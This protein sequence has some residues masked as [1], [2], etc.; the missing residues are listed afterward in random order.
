MRKSLFL[1]HQRTLLEPFHDVLLEKWKEGATQAQIWNW[2]K[3]N[4]PLVTHG[5]INQFF[6]SRNC[7]RNRS[8]WSKLRGTITKECRLCHKTYEAVQAHQKWCLTCCPDIRSRTLMTYY[9]ITKQ[10][11]DALLDR[12]GNKCALCPRSFVGYEGKICVDHCH[13]TGVVRGILCHWCNYNLGYME[14]K[15]DVVSA[16]LKDST[17]HIVPI[18]PDCH[19]FKPPPWKQRKNKVQGF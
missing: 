19:H 18:N 5:V 2:V 12:Q 10:Q 16:Y 8:E 9:G 7:T 15:V 3:H 17:Q 14:D 13:V 11:Y 6:L 1:E 4:I